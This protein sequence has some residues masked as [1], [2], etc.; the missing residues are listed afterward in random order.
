V[1]NKLLTVSQFPLEELINTH[2]LHSRYVLFLLYYLFSLY[3]RYKM[4]SYTNIMF[5]NNL[6]LHTYAGA[7]G[8]RMYSSHSF[9]ASALDGGEVI[10]FMPQL[11]FTPR[12]RTHS[13]HWIGGWV[14]LR[15][16]LGTE[17]R[18]IIL[19]LCQGS[20]PCCL[21][22]NTILTELPRLNYVAKGSKISKA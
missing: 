6:L 14:G 22:S 3:L 13:T 8:Y 4:H 7:K 18:G 9:L 19:C 20:K 17:T 12:E 1:L 11:L 21:Q 16:G 15:A 5:Q 2:V 10:S